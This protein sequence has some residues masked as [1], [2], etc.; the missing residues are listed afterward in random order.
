MTRQIGT[1]HPTDQV[2]VPPDTVTTFLMTGGS[3]AQAA[4]WLS[5][6]STAAASAA[7]AGVHIV[8][9]TP[10]TTA[11]GTFFCAANLMSTAAAV[12]TS[13]TSIAS[14]G[15]SHPV[16][17]ATLFQVPGGSTGFSFA[18]FSSGI[19]QMEQWRK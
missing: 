17:A 16:M 8:R 11:G 13:G 14:T 4:D 15:V 9:I 7:V 1:L 3:S 10:L 19:V 18:A 5:S 12:P 6:G 2:P